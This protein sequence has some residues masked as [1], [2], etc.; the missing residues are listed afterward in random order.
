MSEIFKT[1]CVVTWKSP[2]DNGGCPITGYNLERRVV[3]TK[4]YLTL[5]KKPLTELTMNVMDLSEGM[6]YEFRVYAINKIGVGEPS[7]PSKP[8][9]AKDPWSERSI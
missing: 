8:F 1:T 7:P 3:G 6:E 9:T 2:E 4:R 5:N